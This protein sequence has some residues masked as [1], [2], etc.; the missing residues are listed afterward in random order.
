MRRYSLTFT[1]VLLILVASIA[2][3]SYGVIVGKEQFYPYKHIQQAYDW[4]RS[5]KVYQWVRKVQIELQKKEWHQLG[6]ALHGLELR[7][8][9][10]AST[11][12]SA[13]FR[14]GG[15]Y[16]IGNQLIG[17]SARGDFFLFDRENERGAIKKIDIELESNLDS[18]LEYLNDRNMNAE[19]ALI[20]FRVTD[21]VV[22]EKESRNFLVASHVYWHELEECYTLRLSRLE[23]EE[24]ERLETISRTSRDWDSVWE[25]APCLKTA[26]RIKQFAT[27]QSGG[28]VVV[29]NSG[30]LLLTVGDFGFDGVRSELNLPQDQTSD[31][32]KVLKINPNTGESEVVSFGHRNPQGLALDRRGRIWATEH[33]PQGGDELNLIEAGENYG[34][35]L[36]THGTHYGTEAW[37]LSFSQG[38]HAG[39]RRPVYAWV[40]SIGV[41]NLIE[42]RGFLTEWDGDLLVASLRRRALIRIRFVEGRV[43]FAEPIEIGKRIRDLDQFEDGTIIMLADDGTITELRA[44]TQTGSP[45]SEWMPSDLDQSQREE[46]L[47]IVTS[48]LECHSVNPSGPQEGSPNLFGIYGKQIAASTYSHYSKS[49]KLSQ[50][51]WDDESLDAFLHDGEDFAPGNVMRYPKIENEKVRHAVIRYLQALKK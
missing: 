49:L 16:A 5:L 29:T 43:I 40:P 25:S 23:L 30:D 2:S 26:L 48:C 27:H 46:V 8:T 21:I 15:I 7:N 3:F 12:P 13:R 31:Y 34:W 32:G 38:R 45:E 6:S 37:P 47:A 9:D 51:V 19:R 1:V 24:S 50:G 4:T 42:V 36:V 44:S 14:G 10:I 28:R 18:F 35:P 39:F 33:G 17:A 11:V 20:S 41:S 22:V